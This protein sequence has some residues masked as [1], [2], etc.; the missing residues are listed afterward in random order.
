[1]TQDAM[2]SGTRDRPP[3]RD[4]ARALVFDPDG[5]LLLIAYEA[6][7][8]IDPRRPEARTFWFMPGGGLEPGETHVEAC[9]RELSEEIGVP[10]AEIGPQ[11]G[12]CDGPFH[13][14]PTP[15]DARERYF[16]V[17]LPDDRIDTG[18]LAETEANPVLGTRWWTLDELEASDARIEPAG[19]A[20]LARRVASGDLPDPPTAL[21]WH[22]S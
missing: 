20:R 8:P 15:R 16:V 2:Q 4:V 5:R 9:R 10:N 22:D 19:L 1:M 18:R 21:R 12:T 17:R 11:V 6:V 7:K 13:L 3:L 14:F